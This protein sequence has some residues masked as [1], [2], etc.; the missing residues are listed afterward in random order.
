M[1]AGTERSAR[2]ECAPSAL[3]VKVLAERG[4]SPEWHGLRLFG[5]G[6][7]AGAFDAGWDRRAETRSPSRG[8]PDSQDCVELGQL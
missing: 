7:R 2:D 4:E 3:S 1:S 8:L 6:R 5:H